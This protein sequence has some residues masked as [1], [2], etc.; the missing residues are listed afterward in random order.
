MSVGDDHIDAMIE[1]VSD[2]LFVDVIEQQLRDARPPVEWT[3]FL[4]P[5]ER[6]IVAVLE[7]PRGGP[8]DFSQVGDLLSRVTTMAE[9]KRSTVERPSDSSRLIRI[10]L[11][12]FAHWMIAFLAFGVKWETVLG[13]AMAVSGVLLICIGTWATVDPYPRQGPSTPKPNVHPPSQGRP[14]PPPPRPSRGSQPPCST[15]GG[16]SPARVRPSFD[17]PPPEYVRK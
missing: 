2:D 5:E 16:A 3:D 13:L 14:P 1:Q 4:S 11:P 9:A 15:G 17:Q 7:E 10:V 6:E 8:V 12:A